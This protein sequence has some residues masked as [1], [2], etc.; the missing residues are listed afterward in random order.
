[1]Y[2]ERYN[3]LLKIDF[4]RIPLPSNRDIYKR[5]S[6]IGK[7]LIR[8][9]LLE[10]DEREG[11]FLQIGFPV[12]G[13]N[14]VERVRYDRKGERV[15]INSTQFFDE[16]PEEVWEY[17]IGAVQVMK[18]FLEGRKGRKLDISEIEHYIRMGNAVWLTI[19]L[20]NEIKNIDFD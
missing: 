15:Y 7:R 11:Q 4:P 17:K 1:V 16:V 8:I 6:E 18:K 12:V 10:F 3:D 5:L 2:H 19:Q 9:H 20:Q 14:V 13:E